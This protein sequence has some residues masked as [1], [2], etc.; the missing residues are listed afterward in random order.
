MKAP[1]YMRAAAAAVILV[2]ASGARSAPPAPPFEVAYRAWEVVTELARHN[3]DPTISGTC[4]KTFR[5]FV[6]PGLRGQTK[7]E[8]EVAAV[9]CLEAARSACMNSKLRTS[10]DTAKKCD[11]FR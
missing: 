10:A 1:R 9:A 8:Q 3:R 4:G 6:S 2:L 7:A 5:P 11:E